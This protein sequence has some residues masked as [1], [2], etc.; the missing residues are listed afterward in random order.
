MSKVRSDMLLH[1][2]VTHLSNLFSLMNDGCE[3]CEIS[4]D[5]V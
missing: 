4:I 3:K 1:S 2:S 5:L